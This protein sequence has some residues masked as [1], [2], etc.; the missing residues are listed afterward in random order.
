MPTTNNNPAPRRDNDGDDVAAVPVTAGKRP[1]NWLYLTPLLLLLLIPLCN[2]RADT[3]DRPVVAATPAP[4]ATAAPVA[5]A[6]PA[7]SVA[8]R[9]ADATANA[10]NRTT[11]AT[12]SATAGAVNAT[13]G[14][15]AALLNPFTVHAAG[16]DMGKAVLNFDANATTPNSDATGV[17]RSVADYLQ[18]N[19][20]A[21]VSL[22]GYTDN[23]GS[24]E[25]NRQLTQKRIETVKSALTGAGVDVGRI[26]MANFGEA[27][28]ITD[29]AS[30]QAREMNRRVEI[31]L[32]R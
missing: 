20:A 15:G 26:A 8:N 19:P 29:N 7:A 9:A 30:P 18:A 24:A 27:Y 28:A 16:P 12:R 2:R 4:V 25:V 1:F 14:A 10:V 13:R 21:R 22:K 32:A 11:D 3:D 17:L 6:S 23:S 31:E 5:V